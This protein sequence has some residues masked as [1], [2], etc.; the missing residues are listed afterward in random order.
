MNEA[1]VT[2]E[3]IIE[4]IKMLSAS[5]GGIKKKVPKSTLDRLR[6]LYISKNFSE[7]IRGIKEICRLKFVLR[8]GYINSH[9][10]SESI[11]KLVLENSR[12]AGFNQVDLE[13]VVSHKID[14]S[15]AFIIHPPSFPIYGTSSFNN[16]KLSMFIFRKFLDTS[17]FESFVFLVAHELS[18]IILCAVN[19]P[20]QHNEIA[21]DM[22]AMMLGFHEVI[23]IGRKYRN[24]T[25]GYLDDNQFRIAY[26]EISRRSQ[27]IYL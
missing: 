6:A 17:P 7:C 13:S 8:I 25:C 2:N 24:M 21:V 3:E 26:E 22:T 5:L 11:Q 18:H 12:Q 4:F 10:G 9:S 16:L 23:K 20:L 15:A 14:I 19:H 1:V 27:I